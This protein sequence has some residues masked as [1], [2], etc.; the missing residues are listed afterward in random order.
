[1]SAEGLNEFAKFLPA[2]EQKGVN[3]G[4]PRN[5]GGNV[6]PMILERLMREAGRANIEG[7]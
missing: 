7:I 4:R 1:L 6:S 2:I 3:N 5:G